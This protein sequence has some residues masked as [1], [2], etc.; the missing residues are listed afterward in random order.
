MN[1]SPIVNIGPPPLFF[2]GTFVFLEKESVRLVRLSCC[3]CSCLFLVSFEAFRPVV[4]K[5]CYADPKG[6]ATKFPGDPWGYISVM[7][8]LKSTYFLIE[9]NVLLK[10]MAGRLY[11]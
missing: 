9:R 4:P 10:I 1:S 5:L 3:V 7:A 8:A 11:L 6:Y 2:S